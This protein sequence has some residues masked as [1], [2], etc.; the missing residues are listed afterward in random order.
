M[1]DLN[2]TDLRDDLVALL[3]TD[4]PICEFCTDA[5]VQP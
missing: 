3:D 1:N 2:L 5:E 4:T